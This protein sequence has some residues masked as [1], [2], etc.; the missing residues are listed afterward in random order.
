MPLEIL[1][2]Q[3]RGRRTFGNSRPASVLTFLPGWRQII[4]PLC[5]L[6]ESVAESGVSSLG[7]EASI[8]YQAHL[9]HPVIFGIP[10]ICN[11]LAIVITAAITWLLVIG[12]KESARFNN[13]IVVLKVIT[14]LFFIAVGTAY[15]KPEIGIRS[16]PAE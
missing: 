10:I 8:A 11:I 5:L 4:V 12:V 6:Q 15:V 3:F 7:P 9:Y 13:I 16:F 1:R 2:L 14:I